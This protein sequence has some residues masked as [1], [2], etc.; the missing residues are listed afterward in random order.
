MKFI[1]GNIKLT[2]GNY[3]DLLHNLQ[4][5]LNFEVEFSETI[6]AIIVKDNENCFVDLDVYSVINGY[7]TNKVNDLTSFITGY[8]R[9]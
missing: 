7:K 1:L 5:Q 9:D 2:D 4:E 3:T 6:K 8:Y